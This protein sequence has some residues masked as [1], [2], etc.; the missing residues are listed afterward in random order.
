MFGDRPAKGVLF[1]ASKVDL[2]GISPDGGTV[3]LHLVRGAPWTGSDEELASFQNKI[4]T[5]VSYA[6]DG[7]MHTDHPETHGLPWAIVVSSLQG[8]PDARCQ[9]VMNVLQAAARPWRATDL[10]PRS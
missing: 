6:V 1:D 5:Y 10:A 2:I 7:Q 8:G 3:Q 9:H 4:Q